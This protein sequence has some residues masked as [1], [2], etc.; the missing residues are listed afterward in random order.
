MYQALG[1][2]SERNVK[3]GKERE[4][5]SR[6]IPWEFIIVDCF[7]AEIVKQRYWKYKGPTGDEELCIV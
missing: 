5:S 1:K 4:A 3:G 7:V 6:E 2:N